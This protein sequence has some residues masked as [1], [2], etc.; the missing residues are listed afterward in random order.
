MRVLSFLDI[1][2]V[3]SGL[4]DKI[5][6]NKNNSVKTV[7]ELQPKKNKPLT[8]HLYPARSHRG[9]GYQKQMC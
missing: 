9:A 7:E 3:E 1:A 4:T 2:T 6:G 8:L 5:S